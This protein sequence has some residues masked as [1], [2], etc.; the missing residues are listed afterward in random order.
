MRYSTR[1]HQAGLQPWLTIGSCGAQHGHQPKLAGHH[2]RHV[3]RLGREDA[4]A[5]DAG[6]GPRV[7][8][9]HQWGMAKLGLAELVLS[10]SHNLPRKRFRRCT[11]HLC[12]R[13]APLGLLGSRA[14]QNC[15]R[16]GGHRHRRC[17]HPHSHTCPRGSTGSP[18]IHRRCTFQQR[19]YY[20]ER[21][22]HPRSTGQHRNRSRR[23]PLVRWC[24]CS[25]RSTPRCRRSMGCR[26]RLSRLAGSRASCQSRRCRTSRQSSRAGFRTR[27]RPPRR[28]CNRAAPPGR[29]ECIHPPRSR[30]AFRGHCTRKKT[31]LRGRHMHRLRCSSGGL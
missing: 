11:P 17:T 20:P 7:R 1:T 16:R 6:E 24:R 27:T 25:Q 31:W 21:S 2:P 19:R 8:G 14:R 15:R 23:R 4:I 9:R 5:V 22:C 30:P 28:R 3:R 10:R 26:I 29:M 13:T 18:H 12:R